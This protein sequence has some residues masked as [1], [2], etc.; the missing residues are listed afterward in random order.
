MK[1]HEG[2]TVARLVD[3]D[4]LYVWTG[5]ADRMMNALDRL[6]LS[7]IIA[8]SP[9][10]FSALTSDAVLST[11]EQLPDRGI[12]KQWVRLGCLEQI[13]DAFR[14]LDLGIVPVP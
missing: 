12:P 10:Q 7:G 8:P 11:F 2:H 13:E 3:G 14:D 6:E 5:P 9:R 1:E 4:N